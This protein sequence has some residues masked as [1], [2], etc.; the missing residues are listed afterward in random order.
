MT[1]LVNLGV[2]FSAFI[3]AVYILTTEY[4]TVWPAPNFVIHSATYDYIF[5]SVAQTFSNPIKIDF[6]YKAKPLAIYSSSLIDEK[7]FNNSQ[8]TL[9]KQSN[10]Y[11]LLHIQPWALVPD[12]ISSHSGNTE[13]LYQIFNSL[14]NKWLNVL[15]SVT[16]MIEIMFSSKTHKNIHFL[17]ACID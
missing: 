16:D 1:I 13:D 8:R 5:D 7:C 2:A 12:R 3:L 9:E 15:A 6:S 4:S 17:H 10:L 14:S 11:H